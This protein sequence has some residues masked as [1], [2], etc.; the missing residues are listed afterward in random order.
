MELDGTIA[1]TPFVLFDCPAWPRIF[2]VYDL[3]PK[4]PDSDEDGDSGT[5]A[6]HACEDDCAGAVDATVGVTDAVDL[7]ARVP[8]LWVLAFVLENDSLMNEKIRVCEAL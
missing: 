8:L 6:V 1:V 4:L 3:L 5:V 7:C 2:V